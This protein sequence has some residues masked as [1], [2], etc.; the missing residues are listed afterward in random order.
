MQSPSTPVRLIR[1]DELL[2]LIPFGKSTL[3]QKIQ[4][5]EFPAPLSLGARAVGWREDEVQAWIDSR[6]RVI[7][8]RRCPANARTG[9]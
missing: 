1:R 7:E 3:F 2:R 9:A 8:P 6:P 4:A 5:G